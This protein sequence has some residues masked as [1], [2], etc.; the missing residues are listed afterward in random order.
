[1]K[2][3]HYWFEFEFELLVFVVCFKIC[4]KIFFSVLWRLIGLN[5]ASGVCKDDDV[6]IFIYPASHL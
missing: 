3:I 6:F 1:M 2:Q 5:I 4:D